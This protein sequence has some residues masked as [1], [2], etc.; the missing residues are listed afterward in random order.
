MNIETESWEQNIGLL[1]QHFNTYPA[2]SVEENI[3]F[4]DI[5]KKYDREKILSAAEKANVTNFVDKYRNGFKQIL[6]IQFENGVDPSWGQW[7]RLGIARTLYKSSPIIILDEPTSSIDA[8]AEYQIFEN[9]N[10]HTKGKTVVYVSHRY[11]TVRDADLICVL[12][13]GRILESGKHK[14]LI[15]LNGEYAKN[16][17]LQAQGYKE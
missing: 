16:F 8:Q 15:N 3:Y 12:K 1:T 10:A 7:Q 14:D 13:G 6:S 17:R 4:G 11:S 5:S 9:I 2:F